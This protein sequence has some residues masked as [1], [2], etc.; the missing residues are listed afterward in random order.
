MDG[1]I[2]FIQNRKNLQS[3]NSLTKKVR[4]NEKKNKKTDAITALNPQNLLQKELNVNDT[5]DTPLT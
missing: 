5:D 4:K 1:R 3:G 2:G